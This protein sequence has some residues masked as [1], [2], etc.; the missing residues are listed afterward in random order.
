LKPFPIYFFF[1]YGHFVVFLA[2]ATFGAGAEIAIHSVSHDGHLTLMGK[3]LIAFSPSFY[4]ISLSLMNI[5]S[6]NIPF[7]KQ[8]SVRFGIA[9]LLLALPLVMSNVSP[10]VFIGVIALLMV[11]LVI[12][13]QIF[14]AKS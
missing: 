9:V 2:I 11:C 6:W 13:E 10:V 8:M 12:F 7:E 14:C 3:M 1:G 5:F 4:L